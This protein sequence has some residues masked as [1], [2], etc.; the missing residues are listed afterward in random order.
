MI[1]GQI[2]VSQLWQLLTEKSSKF[3]KVGACQ[4]GFVSYKPYAPL[5]LRDLMKIGLKRTDMLDFDTVS[6]ILG[7]Y[8]VTC[9][10]DD[11]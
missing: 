9:K 2:S 6:K 3:A 7:K 11:P 5:V 1:P 8:G 10:L 4:V